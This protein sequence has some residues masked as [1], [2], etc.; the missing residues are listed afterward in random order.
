[1]TV[2]QSLPPTSALGVLSPPLPHAATAPRPINNRFAISEPEYH[3]K[4]KTDSPSPREKRPTTLLVKQESVFL[5]YFLFVFVLFWSP[6]RT[7]SNPRVVAQWH[8]SGGAN[9]QRL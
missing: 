8:S 4:I 5:V 3:A 2:N 6:H 9:R 1:M 7:V